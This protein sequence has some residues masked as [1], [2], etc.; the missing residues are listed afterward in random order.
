MNR[1]SAIRVLLS[2]LLL[3]SQQMALS[4]NA[5][6]WK[7]ALAQSM[8]VHE[9][10]DDRLAKAFAADQTCDQ[11]LAFAQIASALG[12]TP[13]TFA[14]P[15]V[16]SSTVVRSASQAPCLRTV[17]PFQSRAPPVVV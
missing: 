13:N 2:L 3:L 15:R 14:V 10:G 11:C 8:H 17:C 5:W 9:D 4:H 7:S 12:S 1:R 16:I 6:H